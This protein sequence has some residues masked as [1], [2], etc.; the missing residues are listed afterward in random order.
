[1]T[2]EDFQKCFTLLENEFGKQ[3][4]IMKN[5]WYKLF[6]V[7]RI[8]ELEEVIRHYLKKI[9]EFPEIYGI[10]EDV[11]WIIKFKKDDAKKAVQEALKMLNN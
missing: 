6:N 5:G 9:K 10:Y 4:E 8:E 11:E 1:M 2:R 3:N 7:Y